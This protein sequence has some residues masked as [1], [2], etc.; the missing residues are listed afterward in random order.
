MRAL[1]PTALI[2]ALLT[3]TGLCTGPLAA[4]AAS[5][6]DDRWHFH[7]VPYLWLPALDASADVT[8]PSLRGADGNEL[9]PISLSADATPDDYLSNLDMAFMLMGE[10][11]KGPWSLYTDLLYTNFGSKDTKVRSVSGPERLLG[12]EISRKARMDISATVWT[13]AGGY[14]ALERDNVE[15]DLMAGFR[16]LTMDSDLKLTLQGSDGRF[17][18]QQKVSLDQDTWDGIIGVRGQIL[19]PG[20]NWFVPYYADIGTGD[21]DLTWQAMLGVGHRF[22]WGEVTLAYRALGYEFD[23][24]DA[25]LTLYGPGLGVGFSW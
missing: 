3:A 7:A 2:A 1:Q 17:Y 14:R 8:I 4:T 24:N 13:L 21:S 22:D 23:N 20:S 11:R 6:D 15:L 5:S 10:A 25:D 19:F 16:Y 12:T 18:R 9:G